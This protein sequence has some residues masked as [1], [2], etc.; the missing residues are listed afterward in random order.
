MS[1][2]GQTSACAII[3]AH[4]KTPAAARM[5]AWSFLIG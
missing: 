1:N 4:S 2:I 5:A 3:A